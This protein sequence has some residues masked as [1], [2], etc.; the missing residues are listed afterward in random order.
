M[1]NVKEAETDD[2]G[3]QIHLPKTLGKLEK[4]GKL[5]LDKLMSQDKDDEVADVSAQIS[6]WKHD[7]VFLMQTNEDLCPLLGT[8]YEAHRVAHEGRLMNLNKMMMTME[9]HLPSQHA[10]TADGHKVKSQGLS[11]FLGL[12]SLGPVGPLEALQDRKGRLD[13]S[14]GKNKGGRTTQKKK[15]SQMARSKTIPIIR[16][17]LFYP[18]YRSIS[19]RVRAWPKS[20][21]RLRQICGRDRASCQTGLSLTARCGFSPDTDSPTAAGPGGGKII[22]GPPA[23]MHDTSRGPL[24]HFVL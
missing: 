10:A 15:N 9:P 1:D 24:G 2:V 14:Q 8:D 7:Y 20:A 16:A 11:A 3:Q 6:K 19:I 4:D 18:V 23:H 12:F 17:W 13:S 5:L 22:I 21:H